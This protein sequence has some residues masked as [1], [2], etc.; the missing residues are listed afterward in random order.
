M[1][2][3]AT[4]AEI[5]RFRL[6]PGADSGDFAAAAQGVGIW[7]DSRTGYLR[8]SLSLG[9]DGALSDVILWADMAAAESA[10]AAMMADPAV[11]RFMAMI[12]PATVEMRHEH[13][14]VTSP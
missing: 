8:R 2:T 9:P 11:A 10:A 7:L 5:V 6:I 13:V 3:T 1:T 4:I 14:L 12:D